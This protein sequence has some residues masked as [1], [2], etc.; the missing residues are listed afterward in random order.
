MSSDSWCTPKKLAR[1]LGVFDLDPC[2]NPRSHVR[3]KRTYSLE[4]G[5][6]GLKEEWKG[7]V[8]VNGPYSDPKPWC[9]RLAAHDGPWCSLWKLDPTTKW[10]KILIDAG[11]NWGPFKRRLC[12]EK[13]GKILASANFPSVLIY[14]SWQPPP[15]VQ[16]LLLSVW[17][18]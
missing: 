4:K 14:K 6:D 9:L 18:P 8:F 1:V 3:A 17:K 12:F 10:F 11:A 2:S 15:G 13:E 5:D 16:D 7:S